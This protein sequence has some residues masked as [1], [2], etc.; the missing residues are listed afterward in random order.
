MVFSHSNYGYNSDCPLLIWPQ[1]NRTLDVNR[2][3]TG[4]WRLLI[5]LGTENPSEW[6]VVPQVIVYVHRMTGGLGFSSTWWMRN[7]SGSPGTAADEDPEKVAGEIWCEKIPEIFRFFWPA[8]W[9]LGMVTSF[10]CY[11]K[12]AFTKSS[13]SY[14]FFRIFFLVYIDVLSAL[15][16]HHII[17]VSFSRPSC[18]LWHCHGWNG[19]GSRRSQVHFSRSLPRGAGHGG[20]PLERQAEWRAEGQLFTQQRD[21]KTTWWFSTVM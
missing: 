14:R 6:H 5:H 7:S 4:F 15:K 11:S 19:T 3:D 16:H 12:G 2:S 21:E 8:E 18:H 17:F 10:V 1:I 9:H 20:L 13:R